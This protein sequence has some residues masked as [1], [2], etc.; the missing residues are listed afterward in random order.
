MLVTS[1]REGHSLF[2]GLLHEG[3]SP[4]GMLG[5]RSGPDLV[6]QVNSRGLEYAGLLVIMAPDRMSELFALGWT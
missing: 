5:T 4:L 1:K 3:A 6:I 2:T